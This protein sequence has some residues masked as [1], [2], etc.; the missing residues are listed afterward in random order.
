M[1]R[2]LQSTKEIRKCFKLIRAII[3][4]NDHIVFAQWIERLIWVSENTRVRDVIL[5]EH[6]NKLAV[7]G[8]F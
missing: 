8:L 3:L 1:D 6:R 5:L 2:H 7:D 4:D